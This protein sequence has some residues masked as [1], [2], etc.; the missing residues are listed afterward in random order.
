M[1]LLVTKTNIFILIILATSQLIMLTHQ[2][3]LFKAVKV[4]RFK[5]VNSKGSHGGSRDGRHSIL[6]LS[7]IHI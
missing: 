2:E 6:E 3:R 4:A 5:N 1:V 7:L